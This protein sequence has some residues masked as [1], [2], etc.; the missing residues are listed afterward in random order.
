MDESPSGVSTELTAF[1]PPIVQHTSSSTVANEDAVKTYIDCL[2]YQHDP[3]T[4]IQLA[5]VLEQMP[6]YQKRFPYFGVPLS[7]I[8]QIIDESDLMEDTPVQA[9]LGVSLHEESV[10]TTE[11]APTID[12]AVNVR[13]FQGLVTDAQ[14][15]SDHLITDVA[16]LSCQYTMASSE[17]PTHNIVYAENPRQYDYFIT[18]SDRFALDSVT[19]GETFHKLDAVTFTDTIAGLLQLKAQMLVDTYTQEEMVGVYTN[20]FVNPLLSAFAASQEQHGQ[21][22]VSEPS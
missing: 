4:T 17:S 16:L 22:S 20:R 10:L 3:V 2:P 5:W 6:D 19:G 14:T 9:V 21:F 12:G 7:E 13:D 8:A 15:S 18:F 11:D 1:D